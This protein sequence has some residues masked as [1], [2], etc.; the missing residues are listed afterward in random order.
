[1]Q[2]LMRWMPAVFAAAIFA[3]IPALA[4]TEFESRTRM[5]IIE[6]PEPK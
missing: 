3:A 6:A 5:N 2:G 1:M 4:T